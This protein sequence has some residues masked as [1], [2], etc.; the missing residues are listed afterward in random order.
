MP[1]LSVLFFPVWICGT[2][3][4][5]FLW[6]FKYPF[7]CNHMNR[8]KVCLNN[9]ITECLFSN[10]NSYMKKEMLY[11]FDSEFRVASSFSS[12]RSEIKWNVNLYMYDSNNGGLQELELLSVSSQGWLSYFLGKSGAT[13]K[14]HKGVKPDRSSQWYALLV[15]FFLLV[16]LKHTGGSNDTPQEVLQS[17]WI[18]MENMKIQMWCHC[19]QGH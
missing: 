12:S 15:F 18:I 9:T 10:D 1:S 16:I 3:K 5:K 14:D 6:V 11:F 4:E 2:F 7:L 13:Q 8:I 19:F 17:W